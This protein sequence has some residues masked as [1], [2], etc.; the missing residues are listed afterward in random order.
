MGCRPPLCSGILL[1]SVPVI[2]AQTFIS[3]L[4]GRAAQLEQQAA[5]NT[6]SVSAFAGEAVVRFSRK[7]K[8]N[9]WA[10]YSQCCAFCGKRYQ[11]LSA[12]LSVAHLAT[13]HSSQFD[14]PPKGKKFE[15]AF[16]YDDVRNSLLLCHGFAGSCHQE[17]DNKRITVV[18]NACDSSGVWAVLCGPNSSWFLASEAIKGTLRKFQPHA[19]FHSMSNDILP[20]RRAFRT[21]GIEHS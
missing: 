21:Q 12:V 16:C 2:P 17:C 7:T 13:R 10:A 19:E 20:Q 3:L 9:C 11:Q 4:R 6:D 18:P 8:N 14:T 1:H 5:T 15:R